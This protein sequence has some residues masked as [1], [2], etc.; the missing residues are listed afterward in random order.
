MYAI[1]SA[2]LML[3]RKIKV[4]VECDKDA[5]SVKFSEKGSFQELAKRKST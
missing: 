5:T 2:K 4:R 1:M 3:W